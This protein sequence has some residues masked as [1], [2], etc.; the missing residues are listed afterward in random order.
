MDSL[1][2]GGL[3]SISCVNDLA[4]SAKMFE[5][6]STIAHGVLFIDGSECLQSNV[7]E[8][9]CVIPTLDILS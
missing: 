3:L 5:S 9:S 1:P 4:I 2:F 7:S 6:N 8:M